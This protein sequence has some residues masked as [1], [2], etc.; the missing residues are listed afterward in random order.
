[1][2]AFVQF[3]QSLVWA[4]DHC[5]C[6]SPQTQKFQSSLSLRMAAACKV[7]LMMRALVLTDRTPTPAPR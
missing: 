4:I 1:M 7:A 5:V 2:H 3:T 6:L